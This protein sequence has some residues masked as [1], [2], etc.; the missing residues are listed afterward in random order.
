MAS[1]PLKVRIRAGNDEIEVE[2]ERADIDQL[3]EK[4]W[5][6]RQPTP[7]TSQQRDTGNAGRNRKATRSTSKKTPSSRQSQGSDDPNSFDAHA[8]ANRVKEDDRIQLFQSKII[9]VRADW[10]NKTAFVLWFADTPLTSGQIHKALDALD[11]KGAIQR[12]SNALARN[13]NS[14]ITSEQ[15]KAGATPEYRLAAT[16]K[17]NFEDWLLGATNSNGE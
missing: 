10:Y 4:W 17:T 8:F 1:P 9:N 14:F 12:V 3:L 6:T 5:G 15:R 13:M 11:V 7:E 2:G 16:A